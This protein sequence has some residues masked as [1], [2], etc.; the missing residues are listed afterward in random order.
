MKNEVMNFDV[1]IVGAGP[2]GLAMACHLKKMAL[3]QQTP[4]DVC[5]IEKGA[6]VGAHL[7]SGAILDMRSFQEIFPD[8]RDMHAPIENT[9]TDESFYFFRNMKKSWKIPNIFLPKT[10]HNKN[11]YIIRLGE[12]CSWMAEQAEHLGIHIFTGFAATEVLFNENKVIGVRTGEKGLDK[13]GNRKSSYIHSVDLLANYTVFAEGSHGHLGKQLI[14]KYNLAE[15]KTPQHYAVGFKEIWKLNDKSL[16]SGKIMHTIGWPLSTKATGGGFMYFLNDNEIA[17]GLIVDLNYKNPYLRPYDEFQLFKQQENIRRYLK[18][19]ERIAYGAKSISKGGYYSL[20]KMTFPG[21]FLIGCNAGTLDMSRL[22]GIHTAMKSG[23]IA[24][25]SI[26]DSVSS[27]NNIKMDIYDNFTHKLTNSWLWIELYRSRNIVSS[28]HKFGIF[29]G[30]LFNFIESHLMSY[31]S[32]FFIRDKIQDHKSLNYAFKSSSIK[33]P[34][35][36]NKISF[37]MANSLTLANI[38]HTNN[39]PCHL[40]LCDKKIPIIYNLRFFNEP[41]QRY[42]SAG[43]YEISETVNGEAELIINSQNCIHCKVCDIKDPAQNINWT[44][45]EGGAGPNYVN[46]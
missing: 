35:Y 29:A 42:C 37:D 8:W 27:N 32:F 30:S 38:S 18:N 3:S 5:V 40:V 41:A 31:R 44:A 20:P 23:I 11:N 7:L 15:N 4:L 2:A 16:K 39:Q 1:I 28:L 10:L 6:V 26:I 21:G 33:Y 46:M 19:A 13:S 14:K 22:K 17:L 34:A 45:P 36:D 25:E 9:V 24:A 43:V 12:L